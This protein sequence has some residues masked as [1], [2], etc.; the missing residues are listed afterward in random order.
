MP[1]SCNSNFTETVKGEHI[2][3]EVK[4][5][6]KGNRGGQNYTPQHE[7]YINIQRDKQYITSAYCQMF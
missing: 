7:K 6:V 5:K 4:Q 1:H 2:T 3:A